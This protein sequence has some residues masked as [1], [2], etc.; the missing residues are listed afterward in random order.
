[1][2]F[3]YLIINILI[4]LFPLLF[5]FEHR[6]KYY[7]QLKRIGIS[8]AIIC[9]PFV[10]K[11]L[12]FTQFGI[13]SFNSIYVT[14]I[15]FFT[16]P[17][18]ELLFFITVPYS[19]LFFYELSK[20]FFKERKIKIRKFIYFAIPI[21]IVLGI[22]NLDKFYTSL[23]SFLTSFTLLYS[24]KTEILASLNYWR[25]IFLSLLGFLLINFL[26]TSFPVVIYNSNFITNI[27]ITTIPIEDFL[28]FWNMNTLLIF[29]YILQK[30]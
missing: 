16:I 14:G 27:R 11:D 2:K 28:Y 30:K 4:I 5:S 29:I 19:T 12:I 3:T 7:K 23:I 18:E 25:Y 24:I 17:I 13:W 8:T 9:I 15:K 6:I 1:M 20:Y 26:L 10:I 22:I 21:F